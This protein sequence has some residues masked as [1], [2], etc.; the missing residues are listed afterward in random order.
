MAENSDAAGKKIDRAKIS[1]L[2]SVIVMTTKAATEV[3]E[4]INKD[5]R[6]SDQVKVLMERVQQAGKHRAPEMRLRVQL[7]EVDR[8][9]TQAQQGT[10]AKLAREAQAIGW[11]A[12]ATQIRA[13][14]PLVETMGRRERS[15][16]LRALQARTKKLLDEIITADLENGID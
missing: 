6:V 16:H 1:A 13:K 3:W 8:Y 9:A 11:Q 14:L 12:R 5:D 4:A 15:K 10:G 7:D 2:V